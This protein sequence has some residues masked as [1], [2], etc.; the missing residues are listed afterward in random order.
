MTLSELQAV[1][2]ETGMRGY[3]CEQV[4]K[5]IDDATALIGEL[6]TKNDDLLS[7]IQIL[8]DKVE[9]YK[10][11]EECIREAL[12]G[13]QRLG[14]SVLAEAKQKSETMLREAT[15]SSEELVSQ[16]KARADFLIKDSVNKASTESNSIKKSIENEQK[17]LEMMKSEVASFKTTILNLYKSHLELLSNIP[18]ITVQKNKFEQMANENKKPI[19][20]APPQK[21]EEVAPEIS[22]EEEK[23]IL[24]QTKEFE[25]EKVEEKIEEK[26]EEKIEEKEHKNDYSWKFGDLKFGGNSEKK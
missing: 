26:T 14:S 25:Q 1:Q 21:E 7:K 18:E 12:L 3:K 15:T 19:E 10:K 23:D 16:A 4:D 13:A 6:T 8:A 17:N 9:E 2:F 11:D 20:K 24:E 5:F 22:K